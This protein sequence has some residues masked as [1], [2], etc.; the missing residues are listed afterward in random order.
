MNEDFQKELMT[1]HEAKCPC[2]DRVARIYKRHLHSSVARQLIML[3]RQNPD[4]YVHVSDLIPDGQAGAG[5]FTKAK[6]FGLIY[7]MPHE[8]GKKKK[9]G[10]WKLSRKGRRFV[11]GIE[12]IPTYAIVYED[13]VI[14]WDNDTV[15]IKDCL[16]KKFNYLE[17][18]GK[19]GVFSFMRG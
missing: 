10:Y 9:S 4:G 19:R 17:L 1:N 3:Y 6:Y 12:E 2:C 5:D 18:M 13:N 16:G 8:V 11:E 7:E 14:G 15:T